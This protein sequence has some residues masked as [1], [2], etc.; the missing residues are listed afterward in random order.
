MGIESDFKTHSIPNDFDTVTFKKNNREPIIK[1]VFSDYIVHPY[2]GFDFHDK[3]NGGK[4]P[5][6]STMYGEIIDET[7]KMY[8]F[9][10]YT[11]QLEDEWIGWCP[12]KSCSINIL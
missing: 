11:E 3:Y 5:T 4:P 6:Q 9:K 2:Q 7:E 8:K 12:K 1:V 10:V